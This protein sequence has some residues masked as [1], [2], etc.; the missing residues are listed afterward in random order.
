M[1]RTGPGSFLSYLNE[2][3]VVGEDYGPLIGVS[4]LSGRDVRLPES[5]LEAHVLVLGLSREDRCTFINRVL[6]QVE[7]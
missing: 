7:A 1:K 5:S 6:A 2:L 4:A 3:S